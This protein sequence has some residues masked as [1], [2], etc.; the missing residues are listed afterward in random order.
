MILPKVQMSLS[1]CP[2]GAGASR[3]DRGNRTQADGST[4]AGRHFQETLS[5][6]R[7]QQLRQ[8]FSLRLL[9]DIRDLPIGETGYLTGGRLGLEAIAA[10]PFPLFPQKGG[11]YPDE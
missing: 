10:L 2:T 4:R 3:R 11:G 7:K 1:P 5:E 6:G 8:G 9:G